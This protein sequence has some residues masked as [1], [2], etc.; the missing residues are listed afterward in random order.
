MSKSTTNQKNT[1]LVDV[2]MKGFSTLFFHLIKPFVSIYYHGLKPSNV[3]CTVYTVVLM[4]SFRSWMCWYFMD[5][6]QLADRLIRRHVV[7]KD[8]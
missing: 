2:G 7:S 6:V 1:I 8:F 3:Y 5:Q 4:R